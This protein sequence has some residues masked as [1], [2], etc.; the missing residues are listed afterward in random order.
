MVPGHHPRLDSLLASDTST[1]SAL[2]FRETL[3]KIQLPCILLSVIRNCDCSVGNGTVHRI[4]DKNRRICIHCSEPDGKF[5]KDN[6]TS[7]V[8]HWH[9]K[10]S[11]YI[12]TAP[13]CSE[14]EH[15]QHDKVNEFSINIEPSEL[16]ADE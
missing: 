7:W 4:N 5:M 8:A 11:Q 2:E 14:N 16:T 15:E 6:S 3:R 1:P 12:K 13:C 10:R 9:A